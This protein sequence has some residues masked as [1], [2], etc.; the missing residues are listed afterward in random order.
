M[1]PKQKDSRKLGLNPRLQIL[2]E[3]LQLHSTHLFPIHNS[4][5][6]ATAAHYLPCNRVCLFDSASPSGFPSTLH[7]PQ[8]SGKLLE[9][10]DTHLAMKS[11]CLGAGCFLIVHHLFL[12]SPLTCVMQPRAHVTVRQDELGWFIVEQ[13]RTFTF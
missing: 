5:F 8:E 12:G 10:A 6:C 7:P 11:F 9:C 1:F 2:N 4:N 3:R 13:E